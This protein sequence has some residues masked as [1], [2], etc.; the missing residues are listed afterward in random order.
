[1]LSKTDLD[2]TGGELRAP[3]P[4]FAMVFTDRFTL[5]L[6]GRRLSLDG[7]CPIAGHFLKVATVFVVEDGSD[8]NRSLRVGFALDALGA[9]PPYLVTYEVP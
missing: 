7:Q 8:S 1:M 5:S 9:D 6:A 2:L 4:C 3:F